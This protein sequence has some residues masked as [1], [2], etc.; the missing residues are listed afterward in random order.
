[1][2]VTAAY[3]GVHDSGLMTGAGFGLMSIMARYLSVVSRGV[4]GVNVSL[5]GVFTAAPKRVHAGCCR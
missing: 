2:I 5:I 3:N 1:M 4:E